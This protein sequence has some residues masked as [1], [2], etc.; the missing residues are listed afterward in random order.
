MTRILLA[1]LI[2]SG[3]QTVTLDLSSVSIRQL[4]GNS[5]QL[6]PF[7]FVVTVIRIPF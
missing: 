6:K 2:L 5:E 1:A 7:E 3:C 4:L